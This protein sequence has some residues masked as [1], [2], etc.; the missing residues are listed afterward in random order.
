MR[1]RSGPMRRSNAQRQNNVIAVAAD[2]DIVNEPDDADDAQNDIVVVDRAP[3]LRTPPAQ[4][5]RVSRINV[6][7]VTPLSAETWDDWSYYMRQALQGG[8]VL[9]YVLGEKSL[10]DCGLTDIDA[11]C[12]SGKLKSRIPRVMAQNLGDLMT[13]PEIWRKLTEIHS[14]PGVFAAITSLRTLQKLKFEIGTSITDH[15]FKVA[16]AIDRLKQAKLSFDDLGNAYLIESLP[17]NLQQTV[18]SLMKAEPNCTI[19]RILVHLQD[20]LNRAKWQRGVSKGN[21][22]SNINQSEAMAAMLAEHDRLLKNI[23]NKPTRCTRCKMNG[24]SID[25]CYY[26]HPHLAPKSWKPRYKRKNTNT[27]DDGHQKRMNKS[28]PHVNVTATYA[29]ISSA[30]NIATPDHDA[31]NTMHN[32]WIIDSGATDHFCCNAAWYHG[33]TTKVNE[34]VRVGG[35]A[36]IPVEGRGTVHAQAVVNTNTTIDVMITDVLYVPELKINLLSVARLN[37]AGLTVVFENERCIIRDARGDISGVALRQANNLYYMR[38]QPLKPTNVVLTLQNDKNGAWLELWHRRMCHA[39]KRSILDLFRS[40]LIAEPTNA[41]RTQATKTNAARTNDCRPCISGKQHRNAVS[42]KPA[43]RAERPLALVHT[44][45][46]DFCAMS[47][48]NAQYLFV[49]VDDFSRYVWVKALQRK[50]DAFDTFKQFAAYA[51]KHHAHDG[52]VLQRV[53]SDNGGE[54]T[55]AEFSE[56]MRAKGIQRERATAYAHHQNGVAERMNRTIVECVRTMLNDAALPTTLWAEAAA[57]AAYARNRLPTSA[58]ESMTP[59]EAW[60]GGKPKINHMRAFGCIAYMHVN[61]RYRSKLDSK[62]QQLIFVG[63][64][65]D[66]KAYRLYNKSSRTIFESID[67]VFDET[68]VGEPCSLQR[69]PKAHI[70]L[71]SDN[72]GDTINDNTPG[73]NDDDDD[74]DDDTTPLGNMMTRSQ[75]RKNIPANAKS[76]H[77]E[78]APVSRELRL[79]KDRNKPGPRDVAPST[80]PFAFAAVSDDDEPLTMR[81]ALMR[82]DAA[83]WQAAAQAEIDSLMHNDAWELVVPPRGCHVI[84]S[85]WVLKRKRN[86]D[87]SV[88]LYKGRLCA[89]GC[90]QK[91]GIDFEETYS[92][93]AR[94]ASIRML[95]AFAAQHDYHLHQMDVK[96]AYLNGELSELVFMSQPEGFIVKGKE[97]L[98]CR[99]KKSLYGLKQSGRTWHSKIDNTLKAFGF[100]ALANDHCLYLH[101][102]DTATILVALYVDDLLIAS[103]NLNELIA[104]KQKLASTFEMADLGEADCVLGIEVSRDRDNQTIRITQRRY[105]ESI[106]QKYNMHMC[107]GCDTPMEPKITLM[108]AG[109]DYVVNA[110]VTRTYQSMIG[111]LNFLMVC[112]RPDIAYTMTRLAQHNQ[113]PTSTHFDA[114]KRLLRYLRG[115]TGA[116]ITYSRN[117]DD[118]DHCS[119]IGFCD[120]DWA[121]D[122][123][124]R[125]SVSGFVFMMF[126][127]AVSWKSQRQHTIALSTVEAEYIALSSASTEAQW[128]RPLLSDLGVDMKEPT[129]VRSDSAGAIALSK[130]P[131]HHSRTKHID[132][133]HHHIRQLQEENVLKVVHIAGE[134]NP[135]DVF[136]KA[137][138]RVKHERAVAAIGIITESTVSNS[139][140]IRRRKRASLST[141]TSTPDMIH[142]SEGAHS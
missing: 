89:K 81:A 14:K 26:E 113:K 12:L 10:A 32:D 94:Y 98:V 87:G 24:H 109:D 136:T 103:N 77:A 3:A 123:N 93:V 75:H 36:S 140:N 72:D 121:T 43:T 97:Q 70:D 78:T 95:I 128:W 25:R 126:G 31:L 13:P 27:D 4:Y 101:R 22:V 67:V 33:D 59:F 82:H 122:A 86:V 45:L 135:A 5:Q 73:D 20:E 120:S 104:F 35:G 69:T 88:K 91:Y 53:R 19:N 79:L 125:R 131:Q 44:D 58:L 21:N 114:V 90:S 46:C 9:G 80:I 6:E 66:S 108:N 134:V 62:S 39:N 137:L 83:Q 68:D 61:E 92:P 65:A 52:Y 54:Y 51:E 127:G 29:A 18:E 57:T 49:I 138:E 48:G 71:V 17:D 63:Y 34:F 55:S 141:M 38:L 42:T 107:N 56:F 96:A 60:T 118:D 111:S 105:T 41:D 7:S 84:G 1:L 28:A 15:I 119:L 40:N 74:D 116:G 142:R 2:V 8:G 37:R 110:E 16:G 139:K 47:Q 124:D 132:I 130:N 30:Y 115:S 100:S 23:P 117:T 11:E 106:L 76:I 133:R 85:I 64:S 102:D 50:S 129:V 99:L 112:T